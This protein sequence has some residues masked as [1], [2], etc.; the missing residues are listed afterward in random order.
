[1]VFQL[2]KISNYGSSCPAVARTVLQASKLFSSFSLDEAIK[3]AIS[4]KEFEL[5]RQLLR[6][7]QI[8]DEVLIEVSTAEEEIR[9]NGLRV[10]ARGRVVELPAVIDLQTKAESFLQSAKM[11]IRDTALIL[12]PFYNKNFDHKFHAIATWAETALG[13]NDD[14]TLCVKHWEPWVKKIVTMRNKVD[15][16]TEGP[17]GRLLTCNFRVAEDDITTVLPPAWCL[18]GDQPRP[19]L[20]DMEVIIEGII[21]L[22]EDILVTCL[23]KST[24]R[25][26]LRIYEIPEKER[27]KDCPMRLG[28]TIDLV[29]SR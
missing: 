21:R 9:V 23:M 28:V 3:E 26:P 20:A 1:L 29:V 22:G 5:Q 2:Q 13:G 25:L 15:H 19:I 4:G 7:V 14:L 6:C 24:D 17:G 8:R 16:P 10:Q 12:Q 11:A 18:S 27:D